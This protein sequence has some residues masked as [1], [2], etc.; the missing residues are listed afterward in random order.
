MFTIPCILSNCLSIYPLPFSLTDRTYC[1]AR[2]PGISPRMAE[3]PDNKELSKALTYFLR[4]EY[5][6]RTPVSA[7]EV[8]N[9]LK[10]QGKLKNKEYNWFLGWAFQQKTRVGEYRYEIVRDGANVNLT[11]SPTVE[12]AHAVAVSRR[13]DSRKRRRVG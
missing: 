1:L 9:Q 11:V 2:S 7:M 10:I 13:T 8:F 3:T 12:T 5:A 6:G 4:V